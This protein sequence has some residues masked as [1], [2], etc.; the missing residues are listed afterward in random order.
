MET[1]LIILLIYSLFLI[2]MIRS[3]WRRILRPTKHNGIRIAAFIVTAFFVAGTIW[4]LLGFIRNENGKSFTIGWYALA[5]FMV[6]VLSLYTFL[7]WLLARF[8][9]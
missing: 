2:Y 4:E 5:Y 8:W 9:K 7:C 1:L 6:Q 3:S